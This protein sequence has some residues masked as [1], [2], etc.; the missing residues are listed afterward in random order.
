MTEPTLTPEEALESLEADL[1]S[2]EFCA[3]RFNTFDVE[4]ASLEGDTLTVSLT[5]TPSVFLRC[6]KCGRRDFEN[7]GEKVLTLKD[8]P[9]LGHKLAVRLTLPEVKCKHCGTVTAIR[10][11]AWFISPVSL[12]CTQRFV[13]TFE[14]IYLHAKEGADLTAAY[15]SLGLTQE[16]ASTLTM[17]IL[18]KLLTQVGQES[19]TLRRARR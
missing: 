16:E 12:P 5:A 7:A 10:E 4:G 19:P 6:P 11:L 14:D 15:A 17:N 1:K 8:A 2:P 13:N 9:Y 18:D 3:S